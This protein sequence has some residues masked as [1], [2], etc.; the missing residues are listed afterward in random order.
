M[1]IGCENLLILLG[2]Y[3]G[4]I[5]FQMRRKQTVLAHNISLFWIRDKDPLWPFI[6]DIDQAFFAEGVFLGVFGTKILRVLLRVFTVTITS[7]FTP[8]PPPPQCFPQLGFVYNFSL[9]TFE[10]SIVLSLITL[11]LY[12]TTFYAITTII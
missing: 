8:P 10:S 7:C 3:Y 6:L 12:K 2:K 1:E 5:Y 9:F 11:Y 4:H